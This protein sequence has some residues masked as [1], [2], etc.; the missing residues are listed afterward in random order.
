ME[1]LLEKGCDIC[2]VQETFLMEN[3]NAKLKEINEFGFEV[4]SNPR[5][6][7]S[8]GGIA[9]IYKNDLK[10][11]CN[12]RLNNISLKSFYVYILKVSIFHNIIY[13]RMG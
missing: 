5:K 12:F 4:I 11:K 3:D 8:G 6:H 13:H 1:H 9:T 7:R 2:M 10:I